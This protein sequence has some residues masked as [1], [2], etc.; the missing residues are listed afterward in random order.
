VHLITEPVTEL[1]EHVNAVSTPFF[2]RV[3]VVRLVDPDTPY[4]LTDS[5]LNV[6]ATGI[7]IP[8]NSGLLLTFSVVPFNAR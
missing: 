4:K 2:T 5:T 6:Q 8:P 1:A 7:D 3:K